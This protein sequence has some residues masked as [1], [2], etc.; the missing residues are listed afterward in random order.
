MASVHP[1]FVLTKLTSQFGDAGQISP[2]ESA[3]GFLKVCPS[4]LL[5]GRHS[6]PHLTSPPLFAVC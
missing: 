2:E 6:C 1:G 5:G 4:C 3:T